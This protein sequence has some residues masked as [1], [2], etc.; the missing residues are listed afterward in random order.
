MLPVMQGVLESLR[1]YPERLQAKLDPAMLATDLADY[2]VRHGLPFR[3]AH[4]VAG[5]AVRLAESKGI[6]LQELP[7]EE[8][9]ALSALFDADV[10]KVFDFKVSINRR[11]LPGGRGEAAVRAQ[12][13][14]AR[15]E[16]EKD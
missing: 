5:Q 6:S 7:L 9:Q 16:I 15:R 4:A 10:R 8:L 13:R 14:Q 11:S 12:M 1:V 3:Q 2:L